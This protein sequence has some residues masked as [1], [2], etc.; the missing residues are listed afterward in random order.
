MRLY[1]LS[2]PRKA[3]RTGPWRSRTLYQAGERTP[4]QHMSALDAV[5][6]VVVVTVDA[7]RPA[8]L[9]CYGY[10]YDVSP[11]IDEIADEGVRFDRAYTC[12]NSTYPSVTSIHSGAHPA[13]VVVNHGGRIT[14]PEKQRAES[15]NTVPKELSDRDGF[16][17]AWCGG[18][19]GMWHKRGFDHFPP[20][21][22]SHEKRI[23]FEDADTRARVRGLLERVSGTFADVVSDSYYR[24]EQGVGRLKERLRAAE[25]DEAG[26]EIDTLLGQFDAATDGGDRFYGYVHLTETHTPYDADEE[27]IERY[28]AEHDY[29][30]DEPLE[31]V[32]D[33]D[34]P[35]CSAVATAPYTDGWFDDRDWEV[36]VARWLA[37]YDACVTEADRKV[38]RLVDGLEARGAL[39]DTLLVVLADHGESLDENG[40]Y[41]S[42]D[43]LYEPVIRVP[44]VVRAPG[45]ETGA[46][47]DFVQPF[48]IA[49][50]VAEAFD[51]P[52]G[53]FDFHGQSLAPY[54]D[55]EAAA[56]RE[57]VVVE[58]ASSQRRRA[59][60]KGDYKY[61]YRPEDD[62]GDIHDDAVTCRKCGHEHWP[63]E[64][65]F[66][67]SADPDEAENL[68]EDEPDVAED[69]RETAERLVEGYTIGEVDGTADVSY[70]EEEDLEER[71]KHLGYK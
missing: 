14:D 61:I 34:P 20:L 69:L 37:R 4:R 43:G 36:G 12:A 62:L 18:V 71:L 10:E 30:D 27:L 57:A 22:P 31:H 32:T 13:N 23:L 48:D 26:D 54:L 5:Q 63:E 66:D 17:S 11:N 51:L 45:G 50:T 56:E 21:R 47:E 29:P 42:H 2:F 52:A 65:L 24:F 44:F 60:R 41:F 9:G 28:L 53:A 67:L 1:L 68:V 33:P 64:E 16:Y 19:F 3:G 58:M 6:H 15:L 55:G 35:N 25:T 39:E 46:V 59:V 7:L 49:P 38:G 70:E 40:I 8:N